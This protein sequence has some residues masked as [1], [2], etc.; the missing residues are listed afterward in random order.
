MKLTLPAIFSQRD[1]QWGS[2]TLGFNDPSAKDKFKNPFS[3]SW[4]GCLI[5]SLGMLTNRKPNEVNDVLKQNNGFVV[6]S[7]IFVW[8]ASSSL[9]LTQE[10]LSPEWNGPVTDLGITKAKEYLDNGKALVCEVDFNPATPN[11]EQHFLVVN[12]YQDENFICADPWTG[13]EHSMDNYGGFRRAV[14][15]F[16]VYNKVF[17]K[18]SVPA[19]TDDVL[20]Q[21]ADAFIAVASELGT[22]ATKDSVIGKIRGMVEEIKQLEDT[23]QE[24]ERENTALNEQIETIKKEATELE[25]KV[26]QLTQKSVDAQKELES[27]QV[28]HTKEIS[29]IQADHQKQITDLQ[30]SHEKDIEGWKD[31]YAKIEVI[32]KGLGNRIEELKNTVPIEKLS[33]WSLIR[34]GISRWFGS[35]QGTV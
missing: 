7:G 21:R 25:G 17:P 3:L 13:T 34:L 32:A 4:Y 22:T 10:Y 12:G 8:G 19:P 31:K 2:V 23:N 29:D 26:G 9:G 11:E 6:K 16:R 35:Q 20:A 15:R 28:T 27:L 14:I 5:T 18:D 24:R 30:T 1:P 33:G